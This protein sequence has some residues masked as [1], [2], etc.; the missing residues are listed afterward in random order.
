MGL[1]ESEK[2]SDWKGNPNYASNDEAQ[3][4]E[5][6]EKVE[7]SCHSERLWP[8]HPQQTTKDYVYA[9]FASYQDRKYADAQVVVM[10]DFFQDECGNMY[11]AYW[12]TSFLSDE[13]TMHTLL[14][15]G[16]R[17]VRR[18]NGSPGDYTFGT[19]FY[20]N[21]NEFLFLAKMPIEE[22]WK[23]KLSQEDALNAG[24]R[25]IHHQWIRD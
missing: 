8:T 17:L 18:P 16:R 9:V 24:F 23:V 2:L 25:L 20:V 14:S 21:E 1:P 13:E 12:L 3:A 5:S 15:L 6:M 4:P 10:S 19:T 7:I 22:E 11:K